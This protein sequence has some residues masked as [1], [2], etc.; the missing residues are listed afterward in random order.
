MWTAL[1]AGGDTQPHEKSDCESVPRGQAAARD[2]E[3]TPQT[4]AA[5]TPPLAANEPYADCRPCAN[6]L[7]KQFVGPRPIDEEIVCVDSCR[8]LLITRCAAEVPAPKRLKN[9]PPDFE[10]TVNG[11][12]HPVEVTSIA[13]TETVARHAQS[14]AFA[15]LVR[16]RATDA[17]I[18]TGKYAISFTRSIQPPRPSSPAGRQLL[19]DSLAYINRTQNHNEVGEAELIT[20]LNGGTIS[21]KKISREGSAVGAL[22][23]DAAQWEGQTIADLSVLIQQCI[24]AKLR[25][26]ANHNVPANNT[27]LLLYDAHGY[28][29]PDLIA[30]ALLSVTGYTEFHSLYVAA[31]FT[32]RTNDLSPSEPGRE[33]IFLFSRNC[34][35]NGKTTIAA[36]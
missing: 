30:E 19:V 12:L 13:A 18:L 24:D 4:P 25:T 1:T 26:L 9:D 31:S 33:G 15:K 20:A 21:I 11:Q 17:R 29:T 3:A 34:N 22:I 5:G 16:R 8:H 6:M 14:M 2:M 7:L 10:M 28:G 32:N 35:W 36:T 23:T 27:L